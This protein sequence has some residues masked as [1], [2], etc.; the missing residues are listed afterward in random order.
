MKL[1]MMALL[2][3]LLACSGK[4]NSP[5]PGTTGDAQSSTGDDSD[6][7][8]D[9]NNDDTQT[10]DAAPGTDPGPDAGPGSDDDDDDPG[11]V[12][13][14]VSVALVPDG[15]SGSQRVNFA[16][17]LAPGELT[18]ES[19]IKVTADGNEIA[20]Y[21]RGL[22]DYDDGSWRSVQLQVEVDVSTVD[23]LTVAIG[24][25]PSAG[26]LEPVPVGET[27]EFGGEMAT[28]RVWAMLPPQ[29]LAASQVS[30]PTM[31]AS[32]VDAA[33]AAWDGVCDYDRYDTSVF[34]EERPGDRG[35]WLYDR[36]TLMYR[37]Y[38]LTG[39]RS[40]LESA[41]REA[42]VYLNGLS[43]HGTDTRIGIP[44]AESDVKYHY[45]QGM[46][47][48]YLLTGDDRFRQAVEDV[49]DRMSELWPSPG[50]AGGADFWTERHA[51]FALLAYVWAATVSDDRAADFLALADE[52]VD[53]YLDVQSTYGDGGCFA[54]EADAHGEGYGTMGCSPWMSAILADG[55]EAYATLRGGDRAV[56]ARE[57]IVRLGKFMAENRDGDGKPYYWAEADGN[58]G[59][60]D[61]YDE[62]WGE[63]AY[64]AA[65]A[66]HLSGRTDDSL[67]QAALE[68]LD[69]LRQN[70]SAPH[71]RSF[72]WQC[73]SAPL[74]P[75]YL[76]E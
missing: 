36:V 59:E 68:L 29:A 74:T 25:V 46:A 61:S 9:N 2:C 19:H 70:G 67:R 44:T 40:P 65:M 55:L 18:D 47:I 5:D 62:H 52:A 49:A 75:Y 1:V 35:P 8:N 41:Y 26:T 28:P 14:E 53:A 37:G 12:A 60:V 22:A 38:A 30:G 48:H 64:L 13:R 11:S 3:P 51:G 15:V 69:G 23:S 39:D 50:Y 24:A 31:P 16:V 71:I 27:L 4:I 58:G 45:T 32:R 72:N 34:L 66:W 6:N 63:G 76:S 21:R 7:D 54:H 10:A 43:G 56:A 57:S 20:A 42:H 17:P 73:R 33:L